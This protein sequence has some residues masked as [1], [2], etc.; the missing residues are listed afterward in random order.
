MCRIDGAEY[1]EVSLTLSRTARKPHE[2]YEC[3]R[4]IQIG[5]RYL[6]CGLLSEKKWDTFKTCSHCEI[7]EN[8]LTKNCGGF[9][10]GDIRSDIEEHADEYP[11]LAFGLARLAVGM[12]RKWRRFDD[13]GLMADPAMPRSILSA[14]R[15]ESR[16]AGVPRS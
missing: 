14:I 6:R 11:S 10:F 13:A 5:E 12:R 7:A 9:I 3:G 1:A 16:A 2:C 4:Q 8:W 15:D